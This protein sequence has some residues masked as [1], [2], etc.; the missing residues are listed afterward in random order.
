MSLRVCQVVSS[1]DI[2]GIERWL[3]NVNRHLA[4]MHGTDVQMDFLPLF[5]REGALAPEIE[6]S[7][8]Q[9]HDLRF[10]WST[11][12]RGFRELRSIF[13]AGRFDVVHCHADYLGGVVLP[14]AARAGVPFK[15]NHIH[16]T[17]FAFDAPDRPWRWLGGK[18]LRQVALRFADLTVGCSADALAAFVGPAATRGPTAV[19]YC[20]TPLAAYQEATRAGRSEARAALGMAPEQ[21]CIVHVGRHVE[22]KNVSFLLESFRALRTRG[23]RA[24]LLL[25]GSGPLTARLQG[26]AER[27]GL[28]GVVHFLG[29]RADVPM[30]L[31]AASVLALPSIYE[32][33]PVAVI[34]AQAAGVRCLISD[35]ITAEVGVVP[36]LVTRAPLSIG[37]SGWA[38][39][40]E[41]ELAKPPFDAGWAFEKVSR[42]AFDLAT[43]SERLLDIYRAGVRTTSAEVS[44]A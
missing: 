32:G 5:G 43:G 11:A 28:Q 19:L 35:H 33:L 26:E 13:E 21:A 27:L 18:A 41:R 38:E 16:N 40:L 12:G 39:Q 9:I 17:R 34:E 22:P 23:G 7:G 30:I 44:R 3:L 10:S 24:H 29:D 8:S 31:R 4:A 1:L 36:E 25:V 6:A 20:G 37:A 15:V 2:G 42:S 14:A